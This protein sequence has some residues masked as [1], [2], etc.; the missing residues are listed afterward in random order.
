MRDRPTLACSTQAGPG[1]AVFVST[2]ATDS[3]AGQARPCAVLF[4][5]A[6]CA[7]THRAIAHNAW[8]PHHAEVAR[9][10]RVSSQT[11]G[12]MPSSRPALSLLKNRAL[13]PN[14]SRRSVAKPARVPRALRF[15]DWKA[16]GATGWP[17]VGCGFRNP[18]TQ[19]PATSIQAT[20][21]R[22]CLPP[23]RCVP[24]SPHCC[25]TATRTT[26]IFF[27]CEPGAGRENPIPAPQQVVT[28]RVGFP[29][30]GTVHNPT[31]THA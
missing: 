8:H 2:L 3:R 9:A 15:Q 16:C 14:C 18:A 26:Q 11:E 13:N 7:Q 10:K 4:F 27:E 12:D 30:N 17:N 20:T 6:P 23:V 29:E 24:R 1:P 31:P 21:F 22:V 5:P 25:A 28:N 19:C